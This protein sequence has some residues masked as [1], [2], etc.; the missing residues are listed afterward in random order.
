MLLDSN[1]L[2][3]GASG[4]YPALDKILDREDLAVASITRIETL[5]FHKLSPSH[6]IWFETAFR[7]IQIL[8]LHEWS[9]VILTTSKW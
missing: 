2:I 8:P 6:R 7:R 9:R 1:I 4:D 3:Y 5:G